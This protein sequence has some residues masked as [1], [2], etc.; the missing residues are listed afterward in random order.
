MMRPTFIIP[1]LTVLSIVTAVVLW[2]LIYVA[3]Q[4]TGSGT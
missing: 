4:I 2:K 3:L 1:T